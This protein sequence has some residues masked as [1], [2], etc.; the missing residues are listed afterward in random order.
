MG[1]C[2]SITLSCNDYEVY[3]ILFSHYRKMNGAFVVFD[4]SRKKTFENLPFWLQNLE[5]RGEA[6][7]QIGIL[8]HKSDMKKR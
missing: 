7:I 6:N 2:R 4:L 5:E 1:Y 8:G 3:Y